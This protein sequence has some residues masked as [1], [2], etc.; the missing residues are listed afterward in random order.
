MFVFQG[1]LNISGLFINP[2]EIR[3]QVISQNISLSSEALDIFFNASVDGILPVEQGELASENHWFE[4]VDDVDGLD[5]LVRIAAHSE[6]QLCLDYRACGKAGT[7]AV[8]YIDVSMTP[9]EVTIVARSVDDFVAALVAARPK[10]T[11]G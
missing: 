11:G 4:S 1:G 5:C 7:P 10:E 6:S 3:Q 8:T 9:T 2:E